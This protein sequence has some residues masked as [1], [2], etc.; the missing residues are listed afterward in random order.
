M[1]EESNVAV[2]VGDVSL[3]LSA[4]AH[5][6][7]SNTRQCLVFWVCLDGNDPL[8]ADASGILFV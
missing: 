8:L 2:W 4:L 7:G 6:L 5:A 1:V 3:T